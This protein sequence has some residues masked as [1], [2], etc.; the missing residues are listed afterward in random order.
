MAGDRKTRIRTPVLSGTAESGVTVEVT[1]AGRSYTTVASNGRWSLS[2]PASDALPDGIY[3]PTARAVDDTGNATTASLATLEIDGTP[4]G[5]PIVVLDPASDTG[6]PGDNRTRDTTPTIRGNSEP[7]ATVLLTLNGKTYAPAPDALGAWTFTVP[8]ADALVDAAYVTQVS[9]TDPAGNRLVAEGVRFTVDTTAPALPRGGLDAASDSGVVGDNRTATRAPTL[10]GTAESGSTVDVT[11]I[12]AGRTLVLS[13]QTDGTGNW[14]VSVPQADSLANGTYSVGLKSTDGAGNVSSGVGTPFEIFGVTLAA[15]TIVQVDD[16]VN[17]T[18]RIEANATTDDARPTLRISAPSGSTVRVFD[19]SALLGTALETS[20]GNFTFTPETA[21]AEGPH[22][23]TALAVDAAGNSSPASTAF[24]F[25][26]DAIPP[27]PPVIQVNGPEVVSGTAELASGETLLLRIGGATFDLSTPSG[28]WQLDLRTATPASGSLNLADAPFVAR[29]EVRDAPGN[30]AMAVRGTER[31]DLITLLADDIARLIA[32]TQT[33]QGDA[34]FDTVALGSAGAVLNLALIDD[35]AI[36]GVERM[37]IGRNTLIVTASDVRALGGT[38]LVVTGEAGGL[39]RL[40]GSNWSAAGEVAADGVTYAVYTAE[41]VSVRIQAGLDSTV[42]ASPLGL[43][44]GAAA[45]SLV[46]DPAA[47]PVPSST[48]PG[49]LRWGDLLA[50]P[51]ASEQAPW[52]DAASQQDETPVATGADGSSSAAPHA[53]LRLDDLLHVGP[54]MPPAPHR[55]LPVPGDPGGGA[56]L[57]SSAD[58][59]TLRHVAWPWPG[60]DVLPS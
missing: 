29:A 23:L 51:W 20:T 52:R 54:G 58:T 55:A 49:L 11:L 32:G 7:G 45:H 1:L 6:R 26:V 50:S 8:D 27:A 53:V 4:P 47:P 33:V 36:Q 9:V 31:D 57:G 43:H 28:P 17:V 38:E 46:W 13:T 18:G 12:G 35:T 2:I 34:G 48:P 60:D 39:V 30:V 5:V 3:R 40:Q 10:S 15:P 19:G 16:D 37:A 24:T 59:F 42:N 25:I 41:G 44:T 21:L 56:S 22:T 14:K